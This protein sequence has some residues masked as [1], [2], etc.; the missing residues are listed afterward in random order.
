[1]AS[2]P[3]SIARGWARHA[4]SQ[5]PDDYRLI[6]ALREPLVWL[7]E[8]CL[9]SE[10]L[11]RSESK[12][13]AITEA[14]AEDLAV[15]W[16]HFADYDRAAAWSERLLHFTPRDPLALG[17]HGATVYMQGERSIGEAYTMVALQLSGGLAGQ[18]TDTSFVWSNVVGFRTPLV[19]SHFRVKCAE[20]AILQGHFEDFELIEYARS[21]RQSGEIV[22]AK[23]FVDSALE[24]SPTGSELN[25]ELCALL[26]ELREASEPQENA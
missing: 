11:A 15:A 6:K 5:R 23:Q 13:S 10:Q 12:L 9:A 20:D 17:M 25:Q 4:L 1:M 8:I 2:E 22:L 24:T 3:K 18:R 14:A 16:F 21:L 7:G 26:L 19:S